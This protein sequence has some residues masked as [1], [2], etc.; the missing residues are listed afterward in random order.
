MRRRG[1]EA[2]W[3]GWEERMGRSWEEVFPR[4]PVM[5]IVIFLFSFFF[6]LF[7][8]FFGSVFLGGGR[9]W[10]WIEEGRSFDSCGV[11]ENGIKVSKSEKVSK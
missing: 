11:G 10:V 3:L 4:E 8:F 1:S 6:F 7:I 5:R 2:L 9:G